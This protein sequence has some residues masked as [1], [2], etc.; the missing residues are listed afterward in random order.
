[1]KDVVLLGDI[2][3]GITIQEVIGVLDEAINIAHENHQ[4]VYR[5]QNCRD[6]L[7]YILN[8]APPELHRAIMKSDTALVDRDQDGISVIYSKR[9]V[10]PT[11]VYSS[12]VRDAAKQFCNF[13]GLSNF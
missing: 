4:P 2:M 10:V 12:R 13:L 6:K 7:D 11:D 8:N 9:P 1:M 3:K 5:M